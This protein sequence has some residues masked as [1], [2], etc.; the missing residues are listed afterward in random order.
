VHGFADA[1]LIVIVAAGLAPGCR[2]AAFTVTVMAPGTVCGPAG[3][4]TA[5]EP[6]TDR[7]TVAGPA[8]IVPMDNDPVCVPPLGTEIDNCAGLGETENALNE[9]ET[10]TVAAA[11]PFPGVI[12]NAPEAP[13]GGTRLAFGVRVSVHDA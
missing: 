1:Q 12:V 8:S 4:V 7:V 2:L 5:L 11:A 3:T 10:F 9:N 13:E 6:V